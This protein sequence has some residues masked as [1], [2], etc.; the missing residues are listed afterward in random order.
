MA[1]HP[2]AVLLRGA[3]QAFTA[4]DIAALTATFHEDLQGHIAGDNPFAG[5]HRGRD[6]WFGL[7]RRLGELSGGTWKSEV[8]DI[9]ANDRH[10][11]AL[12]HVTAS[13]DGKQLDLLGAHVYHV[14]KGK[15]TEAWW[16]WQDQRAFDEFWT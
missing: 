1:D 5:D 10:A 4:A 2:N 9:V 15:I 3:F 6:T 8:H 16:V 7:L 14:I 13:R 11:I 12:T